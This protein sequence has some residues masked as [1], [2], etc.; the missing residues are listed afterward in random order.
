[1]SFLSKV[2]GEAHCAI[3]NS[4]GSDKYLFW[5]AGICDDSGYHSGIRGIQR[6]L[7]KSFQESRNKLHKHFTRWLCLSLSLSLTVLVCACVINILKWTQTNL[8]GFGPENCTSASG[9]LKLFLYGDRIDS[10]VLCISLCA[11]RWRHILKMT[12]SLPACCGGS[13]MFQLWPLPWWVHC[14]PSLFGPA[15][16]QFS[17][18]IV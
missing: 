3:Q 11:T 6:V 16:D 4:S 7:E 8:F 10:N 15:L 17:T 5:Q 12:P 9:C 1:M 13:V 2:S 18:A 14:P